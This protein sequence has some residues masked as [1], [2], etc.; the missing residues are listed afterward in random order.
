VYTYAAGLGWELPNMI[1]TA[2]SYLIGVS[3]MLFAFNVVRS[4]RSGER[5]PSDPW[6]APDL[7]WA[8]ASPPPA[9]NFDEIP[10]V[11]G[12]HPLWA[13]AQANPRDELPALDGLRSDRRE[14]LLTSPVDAVPTNRWAMPD[15]SIWPLWSAIALTIVF[16]W[17]IFDQWG[18][19]WGAI[20]V[21]IA[22]T[23]WFWPKKSDPSLGGGP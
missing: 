5:A 9:Y 23:I 14:A 20:P 11:E 21:A 18:V 17:S 19:V 3:V 7:A 6:G 1:A 13:D 2:G 10:L 15:P 8:T 4:I 16:V 22:M 12:R